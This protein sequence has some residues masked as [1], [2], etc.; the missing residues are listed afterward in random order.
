MDNLLL[1]FAINRITLT[2]NRIGPGIAGGVVVFV[3][4]YII[5][6]EL[7]RCCEAK[8]LPGKIMLE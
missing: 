6:V 7:R 5:S 8:I 2:N 4:V 1:K 3:E